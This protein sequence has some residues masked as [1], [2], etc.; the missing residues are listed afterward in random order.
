M[1][2]YKKKIAIVTGGGSG[3]GKSI[4]TVLCRAGATV[5]IVDLNQE[6]LDAVVG[7]LRSSGG[8][9]YGQS[10]DVVKPDN[11]S[12]V[13][14]E[15]ASDSGA[16]DVLVNSA[17]IS[18][19]GNIETT[20]EEDF[21]RLFNVNVKGV[22][23]SMRAAVP[24]MKQ[25]GGVI[26]NIASIAASVGIS[27]R[28]AYSMTKGAVLSM[29]L[30]VA[31]DYVVQG[32]RCNCIS[33][34]RIHTPFVDNFLAKNYPG[35]EQ[36]MFD[37]LS[38]SQPIGRMGTPGEVASLALYLCSDEAAFITGCDYPLDGGFIRLK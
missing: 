4:A 21:T 36:E 23:N 15:I 37:K 7:E 14:A 33:P 19:I 32:I 24:F 20:S 2:N 13:F 27:D 34:A 30:S 10:V 16:I 25:R 8:T 31:R 5:H 35:R 6:S 29:T 1:F 18:H 9:A 22:Y 17:G 28:F 11:V 38:A 3:I 12:T 26:L